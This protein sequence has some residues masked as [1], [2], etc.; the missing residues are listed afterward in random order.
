[1]FFKLFSKQQPHARLGYFDY[2][3]ST[4]E[5]VAMIATIPKLSPMVKGANPSALHQAGVAAKHAL[6]DARA[7]IAR[8][9]HAH[10]NEI[11]FTSSATESDNLAV[12]GLTRALLSQGMAPSE[13]VFFSSL[14]EHAAVQKPIR[15]I[16]SAGAL[17]L[18]LRY[19]Q[20]EPSNAIVV[21]QNVKA[22]IVS[23]MYVHNEIGIVAPLRDIAKRI[24]QLRKS[25]P[26][27]A[28]FFHVDATQ[29]PLYFSLYV[30][31]LGVD[32]LTIGATKLYCPKGVGVLYKRRGIPLEPLYYGGGQEF[33][34][35]PGTEPIELI[36]TFAHALLY[37]DTN[38]EKEFNRIQVLQNYFESQIQDKVP[39][40]SITAQNFPRS[41]HI[42]HVAVQHLE[43][44]LLVIELDALGIAVASKSACKNEDATESDL[45]RA[46]Y[47]SNYGAIRFSFGR[48]T[49][50]E[51][52]DTA[53]RALRYIIE[54][55]ALN[56]SS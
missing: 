53:I 42:S 54:K 1:M 3:S 2:A 6:E 43:S 34:L 9:I 48:W 47:P 17:H 33:G 25:N 29:A 12:G 45:V 30:E 27:V 13:I 15:K 50:K 7:L 5:D 55:Y 52:I 22:V 40:C 44:E 8:T 20:A 38:R 23:V 4:P 31:K 18:P 41:P 21:P 24:R 14:Y 19:D 16:V 36:H 56:S 49:T 37:A 51:S 11:I 39:H 46:L 10:A 35:R 32:L 26:G 28:F